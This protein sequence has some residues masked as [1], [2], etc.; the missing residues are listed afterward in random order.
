MLGLGDYDSPSVD[1]DS[2]A[3]A[4]ALAEEPVAP[5]GAQLSIVDYYDGN[6]GEEAVPPAAPDT[7]VLGVTLDDDAVQRATQRRVGGVQISVVKKP[8]TP[9]HPSSVI[10]ADNEEGE[11]EPSGSGA[12]PA[13]VLPPS[14]TG[15][16]PSEMVAKFRGLVEKTGEGYRVNEHIRNAKAFRN[17]DILEKLVAFFDVRECGTNYP[18]ELYDPAAFPKDDYYEKLEETR[19][20]WEE[21]QAPPLPPPTPRPR[22]RATAAAAP[23]APCAPYA[24]VVPAGSGQDASP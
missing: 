19:R 1:G 10:P 11:A 8:Q 12:P 17:P 18:P 20:K 23:C 9:V 22:A 21:R 16:L 2:P 6:D 7:G 24:P 3:A 13:F 5:A 15:S 14:P 4:P